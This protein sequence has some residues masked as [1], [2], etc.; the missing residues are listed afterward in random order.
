ME[1]L[2]LLTPVDIKPEV[3]YESFYKMIEPLLDGSVQRLRFE[4]AHC[5]KDGSRYPVEVNLQLS[6]QGTRDVFVAIILDITERYNTQMEMDHMAH[7]DSL[8]DLPN[9]LLY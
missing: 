7:H 2:Q 5:R 1:E 8:T 4:T 6:R 9:R 3:S